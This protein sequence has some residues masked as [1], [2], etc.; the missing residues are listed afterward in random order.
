MLGL[1]LGLGLVLTSG[2]GS[3]IDLSLGLH[4]GLQ[5]G[6]FVGF[7]LE[8]CPIPGLWLEL[9]LFLGFGYK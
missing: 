5:L 7:M 4:L 1:Y 2:F 9:R 6:L 3:R 8:F